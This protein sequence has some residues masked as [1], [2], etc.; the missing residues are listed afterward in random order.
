MKWNLFNIF[1][2]FLLCGV[3]A[4]F[5]CDAGKPKETYVPPEPPPEVAPVAQE[6]E[7][8]PERVLTDLKPN[9]SGKADFAKDGDKNVIMAP[10]LVPLGQYVNVRERL[11]IEQ[12]KHAMNLYKASN[13]N[14]GPATHEEFMDKIITANK[15]KLPQL[16]KPDDQY[17]YDP[18]TE[19]L[20]ISTRK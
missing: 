12:V 7:A 18:K 4:G 9:A 20:M 1:T 16:R 19:E 13:D 3:W 17:Q 2:T 8:E 5:G 10:I 15:I 14:K 6:P 11:V